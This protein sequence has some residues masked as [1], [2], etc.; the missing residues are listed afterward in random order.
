MRKGEILFY[1][2]TLFWGLWEIC[3]RRLWK[4]ASLSI[5]APLGNLEGVCL[6]G[7]LET[8]MK[9]GSGNG[10][11]VGALR[12]DPGGRAP[13]LETLKMYK[14]RLW[15]QASLSIG[16]PLGNLEGKFV[17]WGH[18]RNSKRGLWKQTGSLY[19]R[20]ARGT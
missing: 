17:Y 13:L 14:R 9:E 20:S 16:T 7:T 6:P 1:Q 3:K 18:L 4:R 12:G 10:A 2:E 11:S 8:Q 19:R 5:G 15:R